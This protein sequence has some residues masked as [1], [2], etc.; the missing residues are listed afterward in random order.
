MSTDNSNGFCLKMTPCECGE[1]GT[2]FTPN[3]SFEEEYAGFTLHGKKVYTKTVDLGVLSNGKTSIAH[4]IADIDEI[5]D[6][7]IRWG[8][9]T[10]FG[11]TSAN[12]YHV[13]SATKEAIIY[14]SNAPAT[15]KYQPCI[16]TLY[17]TCTNR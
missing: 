14:E 8:N 13:F 15:Y 1:G 7:K 2:V 11:S 12:Y 3:I 17:Y 10:A 16:A 6:A 9:P 5:Y 4:G